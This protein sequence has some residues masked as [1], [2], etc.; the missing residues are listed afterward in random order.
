MSAVVRRSATQIVGALFEPGS[1]VC[2]DRPW[3][4]AGFAPDYVQE[5]REA[6]EAS[7]A[8]EAVVTG[9]A[10]VGTYRVA[11]AVS[12]FRFLGGSMGRVAVERVINALDRAAEAGLPFIGVVASGGTR[13]QEG[14]AAFV[15]M[16]DIAAAF[17]R[18]RAQGLPSLVFLS[19]PTFGG[20]MQRGARSRP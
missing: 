12:E 16:R 20:H 6:A 1:F 4:T 13:M 11:T 9:E 3:N 10:R 19:H 15:R 7:D 17:M 2:W 5:L 14:T 18:H 8:D